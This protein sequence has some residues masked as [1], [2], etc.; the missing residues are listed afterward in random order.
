ESPAA[1]FWAAV[2]KRT[3]KPANLVRRREHAV[4]FWVDPNAAAAAG[5]AAAV[6]DL[7]GTH[8]FTQTFWSNHEGDTYPLITVGMTVFDHSGV[9]TGAGAVG[10]DATTNMIRSEEADF[11]GQR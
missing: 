6:R 1:C 2:A 11:N 4:R 10:V 7:R 5:G 8:G 9:G 3:K